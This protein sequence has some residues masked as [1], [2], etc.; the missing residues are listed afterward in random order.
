[1]HLFSRGSANPMGNGHFYFVN[2]HVTSA[3]WERGKDCV[4]KDPIV[5]RKVTDK[6]TGRMVDLDP[7]WQIASEVIGYRIH[8]PGVFT[9]LMRRSS[10]TQMTQ[11]VVGRRGD[12][13]LSSVI[14][15]K[16]VEIEWLD[17][18]Y[19]HKFKNSTELSIMFV[20]DLFTRQGQ[21][22]RMTGSI[23]MTSSEDPLSSFAGRVMRPLNLNL[24]PKYETAF[25]YDYSHNVFVLDFSNTAKCD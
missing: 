19:K 21:T 20:M 6:N 1:M 10:I 7:D 14:K 9:A 24:K 8:I 11:K 2:A 23:G 16:L 5:E 13:T 15:S 17:L 3:C 25:F 4:T 12:G 22:G 18:Y